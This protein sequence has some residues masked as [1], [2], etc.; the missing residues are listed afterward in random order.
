VVP[1][2]REEALAFNA[3]WKLPSVLTFQLKEFN[4]HIDHSWREKLD[5]SLLYHDMK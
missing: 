2:A 5:A 3:S 1:V 4:N